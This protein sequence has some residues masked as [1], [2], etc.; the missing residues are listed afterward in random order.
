VTGGLASLPQQIKHGAAGGIG[1]RLKRGFR[2]I[3]N[4]TVTHDP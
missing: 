2:G 3:R 4:R 1:E